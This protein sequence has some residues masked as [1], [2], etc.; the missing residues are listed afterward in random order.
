MLDVHTPLGLNLRRWFSIAVITYLLKYLQGQCVD[1]M[2][3]CSLEAHQLNRHA[4]DA[5]GVHGS[6][7]AW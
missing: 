6:A 7:A 3:V 5:L 2:T 4:C 1:L